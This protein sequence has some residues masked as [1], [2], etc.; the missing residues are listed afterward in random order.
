M[1]DL[2][3]VYIH[4]VGSNHIGVKSYEFLFAA[5]T[6][7]SGFVD[8]DEW[9]AMPADG[10]PNPPDA[11]CIEAVG[12]IETNTLTLDLAQNSGELSMWDALDG[13]IALGWENIDGLDAYPEN[14]LVFNIGT[15]KDT[16]IDLLYNK[17]IDL[18]FK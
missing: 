12:L 16:V 8:D 14:R 18:V 1:D 2:V 6:D 5:N 15:T 17:N 10:L 4:Y 3:L 9:S 13:V 7:I 11:E